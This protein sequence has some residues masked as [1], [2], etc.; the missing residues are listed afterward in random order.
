ML[1][2][3][4]DLRITIAGGSPAACASAATHLL[5]SWNAV[6]TECAGNP[7]LVSQLRVFLEEAAARVAL[8]NTE[9]ETPILAAWLP[10]VQAL[11]LDLT[12]PLPPPEALPAED[13]MALTERGV[14]TTRTPGTFRAEAFRATHNGQRY[15]QWDYCA[16]TGR[17]YSGVARSIEAAKRAARQESSENIP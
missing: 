7:G 9:G 15:I 4:P 16:H 12:H 10:H 11:L 17:L 5:Q 2:L 1:L 8:A 3:P 14:S 6:A 13:P